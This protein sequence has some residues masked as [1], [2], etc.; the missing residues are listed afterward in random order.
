MD[1]GRLISATEA[2]ELMEKSLK[3]K[4]SQS[5]VTRLIQSGEIQAQKSVVDLRKT[6]VKLSDVEK[7]IEKAKG[8]VG[9]RAAPVGVY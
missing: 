2:R 7:W 8:E 5:K 6:L 1:Q 3:R 9:D 4:I